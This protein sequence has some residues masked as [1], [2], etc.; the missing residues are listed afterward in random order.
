MHCAC[1]HT[2]S[3]QG[4]FTGDTRRDMRGNTTELEMQHPILYSL[5]AEF[6]ELLDSFIPTSNGLLYV[7]NSLLP[8]FLAWTT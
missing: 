5:L 2:V 6:L 8:I 3:T 7:L 4:D 1:A